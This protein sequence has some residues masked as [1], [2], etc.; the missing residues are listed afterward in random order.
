[1]FLGIDIGTSAVKAVIVGED[2][3]VAHEASAPLEVQRPEPLH[4]EQDPDDWWS[5]ANQA[6]LALPSE[7]R[8]MVRSIGLAGQMHGA[9]LLDSSDRPLR[10][11]ILWNDGRSE[12][13]CAELEAA[14]PQS[15]AITANMAFAGFTAPKLKWV[16]KHEPEVF[17]K[18]AT[19][20]LPK[21]YVR[22]QMT[23][24][25]AT[26]VSDAS[27]TL[28]LDV[29][30]RRWSAAMLAATGLEERHMP[31]LHEGVEVTGTLRNEVARGWGMDEV[32]V[33][34]G[35]GDNAAAAVGAGVVADGDAFISLGTSG[36]S[37]VAT[38]S[39]RADADRG[40]HA[41]CHAIPGRWHQMSVMLSA[42]ASLD[43]AANLL[44]MD[45]VELCE[46][47]RL[48][49]ARATPIFLPYLT[50]ERTPHADSHAKGV[51]FGMTAET[52]PA[53]LARAVLDGVAMG[54][55]DGVDVILAAGSQVES[56]TVVGGGSRSAYWGR[57]IASALERPLVYR[58]SGAVGP[59]LGAGRLAQ[60][61]SGAGTL[62][63]SCA[64]PPVT[65]VVEP[66][67]ELT[68]YFAGRQPRFRALYPV[69]QR[70]FRD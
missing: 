49:E 16:A 51:F 58:E 48:A 66:E 68:D 8:R 45:V 17:A 50:G 11:A 3:S 44:C 28:W 1:M 25:K 30:N 63:G 43:W 53:E 24:G 54:L 18:V 20:L 42:A 46:N 36:V 5:A 23:G 4:S 39:L 7:A 37:F 15:R 38:D 65:D 22:L 26:D 64:P 10:P 33:A 12:A 67:P 2:G 41:F 19:V 31:H 62:Q 40:L 13:E 34:A 27:G 6:V 69:L 9:T 14:E 60:V 32:P 59:A 29:A 35:G 55:R 57:L 47:A 61:A 70:S 56:F 52:G 21:D